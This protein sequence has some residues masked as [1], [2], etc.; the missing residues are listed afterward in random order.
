MEIGS[1]RGLLAVPADVDGEHIGDHDESRLIGRGRLEPAEG[2]ERGGIHHQ[3]QLLGELAA[4]GLGGRLA[5]LGLAA[6]LHERGRA[7]LAHEE[8]PVIRVDDHGGRDMDA[9]GGGHAG[10]VAGGVFA[11]R[12]E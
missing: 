7:G 3:T 10:T 12:G 9:A 1:L 5:G 8:Q 2:R 6:G 4:Q 11:S